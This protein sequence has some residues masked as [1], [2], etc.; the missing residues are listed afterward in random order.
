MLICGYKTTGKDTF[1]KSL[2]G[3]DRTYK[4]VIYSKPNGKKLFSWPRE[5]FRLAFADILKQR[6]KEELG[7]PEDFDVEKRKEEVM[8][9]G[10]TFRMHCIKKGCKMR[11]EDPYYWARLAFD[12]IQ[13]K[14]GIPV[15]TDFRFPQEYD[16]SIKSKGEVFTFRI[17]R[18]EIPIPKIV[19]PEDDPEHS[20]DDFET[21]F[22]VVPFENHEEHLKAAKEL[23]PFYKEYN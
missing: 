7:L 16:Y 3:L 8:A 10:Q 21:D 12:P 1:A 13:D 11:K 18:K 14:E 23:F 6:V 5:L 15:V 17:F 9:D 4:W 20:L 2:L 19:N 22:L